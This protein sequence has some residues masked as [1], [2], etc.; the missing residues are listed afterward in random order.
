MCV[1]IR[2]VRVVIIDEE[3]ERKQH[4]SIGPEDAMKGHRPWRLSSAGLV[5][6]L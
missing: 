3:D 4:K 6:L 2:P 5:R 1:A